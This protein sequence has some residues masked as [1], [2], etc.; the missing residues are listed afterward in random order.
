MLFDVMLHKGSFGNSS[1][2][3]CR[4]VAIGIVPLCRVV[5]PVYKHRDNDFTQWCDLDNDIPALSH[6]VTDLVRSFTLN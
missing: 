6:R 5:T 4:P 2:A 3:E 1:V